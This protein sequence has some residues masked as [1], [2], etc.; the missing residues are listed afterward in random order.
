MLIY[1]LKAYF[2]GVNIYQDWKSAE[3]LNKGERLL[4]VFLV[5][6]G[7]LAYGI[8]YECALSLI[9]F[10]IGQ[11]KEVNRNPNEIGGSPRE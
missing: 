6:E 4:T 5:I 9:S 3:R 1:S 11:E 10:I 2:S 7:H 8:G